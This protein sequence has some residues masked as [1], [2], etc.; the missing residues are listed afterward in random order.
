MFARASKF[1]DELGTSIMET[2][3]PRVES[4]ET[5]EERQVRLAREEEAKQKRKALEEAARKKHAET[6]KLLQQKEEERR[7]RLEK[8]AERRRKRARQMEIKQARNEN[9]FAKGERCVY[10]PKVQVEYDDDGNEVVREDGNKEQKSFDASI[11]GVH[12]EDGVE[13][14][15]Y[16]IKFTRG[17]EEV[18]KQTVKERLNDPPCIVV[19]EGGNGGERDEDGDDGAVEDVWFTLIEA[20]KEKEVRPGFVREKVLMVVLDG[21]IQGEGLENMMKKLPVEDRVI[22]GALGETLIRY[23]TFVALNLAELELQVAATSPVNENTKVADV[24]DGDATNEGAAK[25]D[26]AKEEGAGKEEVY[27]IDKNKD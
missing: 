3:A 6:R 2:V 23:E 9:R 18:E 16:T 21:K 11:V 7:D 15:F 25:E 27:Q 17:E 13:N 22:D 19:E 24:A 26:A 5:E 14:V 10:T 8:D 4:T 1:F 20:C 12:L